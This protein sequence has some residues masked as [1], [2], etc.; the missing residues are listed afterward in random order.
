MSYLRSP[1]LGF[2]CVV[3]LTQSL[4]ALNEENA[5]LRLLPPV[6]D[7]AVSEE[8]LPEPTPAADQSLAGGEGVKEDAEGVAM[9]EDQFMWQDW[10][11]PTSLADTPTVGTTASKWASTDRR[12]TRPR[13]HSAR[14]RTCGAKRT[15]AT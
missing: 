4:L 13:C 2:L 7:A 5:D 12:V 8:T 9:L 3:C 14:A 11:L 6:D 1:I 10:F 15:G